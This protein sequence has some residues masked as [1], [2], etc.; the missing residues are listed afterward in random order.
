MGL[1]PFL[2]SYPFLFPLPRL[3]EQGPS[4]SADKWGQSK[5]LHHA[6]P[7]LIKIIT[8]GEVPTEL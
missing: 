7:G 6:Q 8:A 5:A 4:L 3:S 1:A 2:A